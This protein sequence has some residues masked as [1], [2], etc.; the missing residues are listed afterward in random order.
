MR[1]KPTPGRGDEPGSASLDANAPVVP[2]VN[3]WILLVHPLLLDQLGR[4]AAAA[5]AERTRSR[6]YARQGPNT[7]L[8][9][10]V[11]HMIFREVPEDPSRSRYR[12]GGTLAPQLKHWLR[13]RFGN[14]RFRLFYRYRSSDSKIIVFAWVNDEETLRTYGSSTDAYAVFRRMLGK[15]NPPDDFGAL[16]AE[17]LAP[18][19]VERARAL[20]GQADSEP[21]K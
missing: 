15:G 18:D 5:D 2:V 13:A 1:S 11:R 10:A 8:L 7:K 19:A 9:A 16:I 20:L 17:S 12:H 21:P 6:D 4:L 14:G 3:G